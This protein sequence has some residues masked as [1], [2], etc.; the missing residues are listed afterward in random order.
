MIGP[1]NQSTSFLLRMLSAERPVA[2][3]ELDLTKVRAYLKKT[4]PPSET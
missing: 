1:K 3:A 4:L 2:V